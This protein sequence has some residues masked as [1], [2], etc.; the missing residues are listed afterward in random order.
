M[1]PKKPPAGAGPRRGSPPPPPG[2]DA[3]GEDL[4]LVQR[5]A[6][7]AVPA[8]YVTPIG[9]L[10]RSLPIGVKIYPMMRRHFNP[11]IPA[12][13]PP[14]YRHLRTS[15]SEIN[16]GSFCWF[17]PHHKKCAK[18]RPKL[19]FSTAA[20]ARCHA[21]AVDCVKCWPR[22]KALS[23][24]LWHCRQYIHHRFVARRPPH[25]M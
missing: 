3:E 15:S 6:P 11:E 18:P 2:S 17:V 21:A 22:H 13:R 24:A 4:F 9:R 20:G 8:A 16:A 12:P 10:R 19:R 7:Q 14:G 25:M 23:V 1:N 5:T